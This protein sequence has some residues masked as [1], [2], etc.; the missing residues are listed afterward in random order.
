[1]EAIDR[2]QQ[3]AGGLDERIREIAVQEAAIVEM[4]HKLAELTAPFLSAPKLAAVL[5]VEIA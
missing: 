3:A 1:M 4:E 2:I 5:D